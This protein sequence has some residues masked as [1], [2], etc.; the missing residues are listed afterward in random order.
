[1]DAVL[2]PAPVCSKHVCIRHIV[3]LR[4]SLQKVDPVT[5]FLEFRGNNLTGIHHGNTKGNERRGHMYVLEGTAHR[6]L[7]AD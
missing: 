4:S 1:M 2:K 7:A 6:V 3:S 5:G